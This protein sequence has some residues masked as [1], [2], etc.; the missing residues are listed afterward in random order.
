VISSPRS[1]AA[2][3]LPQPQHVVIWKLRHHVT[4]R[5]IK[6]K[7]KG[8]VVIDSGFSVMMLPFGTLHN[9]GLLGRKI[10]VAPR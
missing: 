6:Q 3:E 2:R 10:T 1:I 4:Y 9:K 7:M 5:M 8:K